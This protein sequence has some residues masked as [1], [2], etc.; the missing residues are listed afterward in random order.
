MC[1]MEPRWVD[2]EVKK[3][4]AR[5]RSKLEFCRKEKERCQKDTG[6]AAE[7]EAMLWTG[8]VMGLS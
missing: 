2:D 6:E 5:V 4:V 1:D 3:T 8:A 7:V